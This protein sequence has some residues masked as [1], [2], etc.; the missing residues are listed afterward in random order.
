MAVAPQNGRGVGTHGCV[1]P[2]QIIW[3]SIEK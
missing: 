2:Y 1:T 3:S